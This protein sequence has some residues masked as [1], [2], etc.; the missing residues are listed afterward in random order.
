MK[1]NCSVDM[2]EDL[3]RDV[4]QYMLHRISSM[5]PGELEAMMT[6]ES[7]LEK[8]RELEAK[9]NRILDLFER[10]MGMKLTDELMALSDSV[11]EVRSHAAYLNG[12]RDGM[13]LWSFLNGWIVPSGQCF[14]TWE[15]ELITPELKLAQTLEKRVGGLAVRR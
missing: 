4:I 11:W 1:I 12:V 9:L 6:T 2:S 10:Q 3:V 7:T 8:R 15:E 14:F 13:R 5:K